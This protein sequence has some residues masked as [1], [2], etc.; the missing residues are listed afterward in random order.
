MATMTTLDNIDPLCRE[1]EKLTCDLRSLSQGSQPSEQDLQACPFLDR[2]SFGF[3]PA[4]CLLGAIPQHP[5]FGTCPHIHTSELVLIDPQ[6]RWAR[7]WSKFYRLGRQ[8]VPEI[9][10]V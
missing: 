1:L 8:L 5:M 4:P 6:K 9:G 7:T 2:W 10:N 3:L